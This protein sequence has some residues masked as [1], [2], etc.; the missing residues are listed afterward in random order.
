MQPK[1]P[2]PDSYWVRPGQLLAGEYPRDWD[3]HLSRLKLRRLL[4]AGVT[5]FLDLTQAGEY[6]LEP[7]AH[8]AEDEAAVA[9]IGADVV[10]ATLAHALANP[11]GRADL[12]AM[13]GQRLGALVVDVGDVDL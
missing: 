1:H 8:L 7:Y 12:G 5:L 9:F 2:I 3:D 11:L 4:E 10:A 13:V 6:G